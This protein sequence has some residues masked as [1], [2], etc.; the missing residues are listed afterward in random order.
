MTCKII[1]TINQK[2]GVGKSTVAVNLSY[3]LANKGKKTLI[4]DMDP[5]AHSSCI[6]CQEI[7]REM[8]I[9]RL[10][11]EKNIKIE[12]LII[13]A[14]VFLETQM[15]IDNL[16]IIPSSIHLA[17][18][19]EQVVGRL[20]REKILQKYIKDIDSIFDFIILDCPPTLGVLAINAIYAANM[21]LIPTNYGRYSLD[22]IADLLNSIKEIKDGQSYK[23]F[24][25][26]NQY[27]RRNT[28]T[29]KFIH[30]VLKE[31]DDFLFTTIIRKNESLNQAQIN[32]I[33]IQLFDSSS[34]GAQD[35]SNL[36]TEV[37]INAA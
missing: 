11:T 6:Y 1:A 9:S 7:R 2:G 33:P 3:E 17:L 24:I 23:Y 36:A 25:L 28:Q 13:P 21:V 16:H 27:D 19:I 37:L 4:I 26:R 14:Q 34:N 18:S 29:N 20:Y 30:Q 5:Q 35:F 15:P 12:D 22:G 32:G 31:F 10:F 8:T